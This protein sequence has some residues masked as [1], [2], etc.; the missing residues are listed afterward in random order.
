MSNNK[1]SNNKYFDCPALMN[2]GRTF[3]DYRPV[4]FVENELQFSNNINNSYEYRQFLI[5]NA[6]KIIDMNN[7][8]NN[9]LNGCSEHKVDIPNFKN[10]CD[11]TVQGVSCKTFDNNGIGNYYKTSIKEEKK[12]LVDSYDPLFNSLSMKG[13]LVKEN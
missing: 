4:S 5:K 8:Y 6:S 11:T 12:D 2:D 13:L 1:I 10:N 3:T 9:K 7:N